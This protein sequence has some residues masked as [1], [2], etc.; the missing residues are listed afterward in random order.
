MNNSKQVYVV[1]LVA[2]WRGP[3]IGEGRGSCNIIVLI[4]PIL[5]PIFPILLSHGKSGPESTCSFLF[6]F[7]SVGDIRDKSYSIGVT[8]QSPLFV[9]PS[10][11]VYSLCGT[12]YA[13]MSVVNVTCVSVPPG[14]YVVV[15]VTGAFRQM[16]VC[17][18]E[19]YTINKGGKLYGMSSDIKSVY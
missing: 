13:N 3:P 9:A 10:P 19:V 16:Q 1:F 6:F 5:F 11:G 2:L 14:R 12:R 18:V 15:Q 4:F 17:E 8:D 7:N